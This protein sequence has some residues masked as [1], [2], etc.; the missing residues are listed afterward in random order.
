MFQNKLATNSTLS[1]TTLKQTLTRTRYFPKVKL[2][3][4]SL[5]PLMERHLFREISESSVPIQFK[6]EEIFYCWCSSFLLENK[7]YFYCLLPSKSCLQVYFLHQGEE[8]S[9]SGVT[10]W[11]LAAEKIALF[12][13]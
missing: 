11:F 5:K 13:F 2:I 7:S 10:Q 8:V 3:Q 12:E 6:Q 1:K 4:I 9:T